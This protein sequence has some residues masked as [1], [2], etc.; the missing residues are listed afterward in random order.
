MLNKNYLLSSLLFAAFFFAFHMG[1]HAQS[2]EVGLRL[3]SFENFDFIYKKE[4]ATNKL[5]R[6]RLGVANIGFTSSNENESISAQFGFAI[7]VENRNAINEKFYFIHGIEPFFSVALASNSRITNWNLQ[8]GLGYVLGFHYN[9][10]D[11]FYV[12]LETIPSLNVG[13][14]LRDDSQ[15]VYAVNAGF[16]SNAI[17]VTVAYR[18]KEKIR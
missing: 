1:G 8:T 16:N 10:N 14:S 9:L 18:F 4:K 3:A 11:E 12:N 5:M 2:K 15:N 13:L 7:G 17:S 6:Y